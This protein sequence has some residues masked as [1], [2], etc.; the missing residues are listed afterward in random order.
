[1]QRHPPR[2]IRERPRRALR[3]HARVPGLRRGLDAVFQSERSRTGR[4]SAERIDP[5]RAGSR[6]SPRPVLVAAQ[7]VSLHHAMFDQLGKGIVHAPQPVA[8]NRLVEGIGQHFDNRS[9]QKLE[10]RPRKPIINAR[11]VVGA[12]RVR[13]LRS[14]DQ[15][16]FPKIQHLPAGDRAESPLLIREQLEVAFVQIH[17][18][19]RRRRSRHAI[20]RRARIL[21]HR[22][23]LQ[24]GDRRPLRS[25]S[26]T[27]QRI[28]E[29]DVL[30]ESDPGPRLFA[31]PHVERE[32]EAVPFRRP[33]DLRYAQRKQQKAGQG[34][35]S[36]MDNES[37]A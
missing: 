33:G 23:E 4:A 12:R 26:R 17:R 2:D 28:L 21:P 25:D 31:R 27:K 19:A 9:Q 30:A 11:R 29:V 13:P 20:L 24:P 8:E 22:R 3:L 32:F 15:P 7:D 10:P 16:S 5:Q 35:A 14:A 18:V 1:M 37:F 6:K 34:I 36:L